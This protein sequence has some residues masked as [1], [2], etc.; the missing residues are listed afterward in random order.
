MD[1]SS[2][3]NLEVEAGSGC[4]DNLVN[5]SLIAVEQPEEEV[6][7]GKGK[8][9]GEEEQSL[10]QEGGQDN[11]DACGADVEVGNET[12]PGVIALHSVSGEAEE[13][14]EGD[15]QEERHPHVPGL[16][17]SSEQNPSTKHNPSRSNAPKL[18]LRIP[19]I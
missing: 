19:L 18:L 16:V 9:E 2:N 17:K 12:Q 8:V 4:S 13:E 6:D 15:R 11:E 10:E 14:G 7:G 1:F 5:H 3:L